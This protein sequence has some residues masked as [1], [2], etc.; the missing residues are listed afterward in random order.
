MPK[1]RLYVPASYSPG[2]MLT[3]DVA[4]SH[5]LANVMRVREGEMIAVFNGQ[6][7]QWNA[8]VARVSKKAVTLELVECVAAQ[9][10][11]PDLWLL[12]SPIKNKMD[13]MVEKAVEL[14]VSALHVVYT[15]HCVIKSIN[16]E[17]I[18][19]YAREAAEQCERHDVPEV[20]EWKDMPALL[21]AWPTD[22]T[23]LHAD[24][25]GGGQNIKTLLAGCKPGKYAVLIG[26]EGGF[27]AEERYMLQRVPQ[28]K[29]FGLGPRILRADTAVAAALACVQAS[30]GDWEMLPHFEAMES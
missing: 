2:V 8:N 14:G 4:Q 26:P 18:D 27:S 22:R 9:K 23:L 10:Q 29:P 17:K 3:L 11:N 12:F 16:R 25:S 1:I 28:V 20:Q 19:I 7:G 30:L 5:Y 13:S 6:D 21:S 15:Q 24:E